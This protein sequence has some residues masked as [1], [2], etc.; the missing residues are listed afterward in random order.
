MSSNGATLGRKRLFAD[1]YTS[2]MQIQW[3]DGDRGPMSSPPAAH[4]GPNP[5]WGRNYLGLLRFDSLISARLIIPDSHLF[6]GVCLLGIGADDLVTQLARPVPGSLRD[7]HTE[8][9]LAIRCREATLPGALNRLLVRPGSEFLNGFT[10][11]S[12]PDAEAADQLAE[13]L[14]ERKLTDLERRQSRFQDPASAVASLLR[15]CLRA[16]GFSSHADEW[17]EPLEAGWRR[18]LESASSIPIET[19]EQ[20]VDFSLVDMLALESIEGDV[21]RMTPDSQACYREILEVVSDGVKN[22]SEITRIIRSFGDGISDESSA[23]IRLLESWYSRG[24][25]RAMAHQHGAA[26][27]QLANDEPF[28]LIQAA[29]E[30]FSRKSRGQTRLELPSEVITGLADLP[31][32]EW[33]TFCSKNGRDLYDWW[34]NGELDSLRRVFEDLSGIL[35]TERPSRTRFSLVAPP[36]T[37]AALAGAGT[38]FVAVGVGMAASGASLASAS[39]SAAVAVAQATRTSKRRTQRRLIEIARAS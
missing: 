11:K 35:V 2:T 34:A 30:R 37:K 39:V 27:V 38:A 36:A 26:F 9:P 4:G 31:A 6:D 17:V 15:D 22:R 1:D 19:Y 29:S 28:G 25:Y 10:F 5:Y 3:R 32:E 13:S 23:E 24:R 20:G 8:L 12:I 14:S 7:G 33:R 18:I 16:D 21:R